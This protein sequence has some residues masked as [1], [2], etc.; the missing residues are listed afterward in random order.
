MHA[1]GCLDVREAAFDFE[2]SDALTKLFDCQTA[3]SDAN[4][5]RCTLTIVCDKSPL[6]LTDCN[7]IRDDVEILHSMLRPSN[8]LTILSV[9]L[10]C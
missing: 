7:V 5:I 3:A 1:G 6:Q 4:V 2:R 10:K 8:A 9:F